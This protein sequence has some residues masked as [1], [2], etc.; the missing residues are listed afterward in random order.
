[1]VSSYGVKPG[2]KL[3]AFATL[4]A[5]SV[6]VLGSFTRLVDAG[7]GCPDWPTCYGHIWAPQTDEQINRAN[8]AF[9]EIPV[10]LEKTWPEMVHRYL[11]SLLGLLILILAAVSFRYRHRPEQPFKL[12][13]LL[14]FMVILQ[15]AFGAW[16]VTLKL[17]P[18]VV[19]AHLL[20][21]FATFTL[22]WLLTLRLRGA[23]TGLR[24]SSAPRQLPRVLAA[25]TLAV[26]I[27]QV[28]LGGWTTSNYA[29][30]ACPDLF[31]CQTQ[32]W[33]EADYIAGF[34]LAHPIGPNYLG[35]HLD[36]PARTAIHMAHRIGA[37]I[38]TVMCLWLI[39]RL[40]A[41]RFAGLASA[42]LLILV[43][44]VTLGLSNIYFGLPLTVAVLHNLGGALLLATVATVNFT[45]Y[46]EA[47]HV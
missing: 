11:A 27:G 42:L 47:K 14:L 37:I 21:G 35:G 30:L 2:F 7:L 40:V 13:L 23:P 16:T 18:Q 41:I 31:T 3:A 39:W 12:P 34:D 45:L 29:A 38:T 24:F 20:G 32:W 4:F 43:A 33:P 1:M 19:T 15:G 28:F 25:L 9:P 10:D 5:I 26:V 22:L 46:R 44:Q 36:V 6:V 17:W 8:E